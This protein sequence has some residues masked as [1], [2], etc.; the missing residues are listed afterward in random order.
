MQQSARC[1]ATDAWLLR[2]EV[3]IAEQWSI[4][5]HATKHPLRSR[6]VSNAV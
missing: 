2:N 5:C 4:N 6:E 1:H 3:L